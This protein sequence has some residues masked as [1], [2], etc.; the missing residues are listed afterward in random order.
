MTSLIRE[1]PYEQ[2]ISIISDNLRRV[3]RITPQRA[4]SPLFQTESDNEAERPDEEYDVKRK[5]PRPRSPSPSPAPQ[6]EEEEPEEETEQPVE[7]DVY[8]RYKKSQRGKY[9]GQMR[10]EIA[11]AQDQDAPMSDEHHHMWSLL[12]ERNPQRGMQQDKNGAR[13]MFVPPEAMAR[14][15]VELG[16]TS[17]R[18]DC[19]ECQTDKNVNGAAKTH[20]DYL[21]SYWRTHRKTVEPA[22]LAKTI[23][24]LFE[25]TIRTP[26]NQRI[27]RNFHK[28][29]QNTKPRLLQSKL[30]PPWT[31]RSVFDHY[32]SHDIE[33]NNEMMNMIWQWKVLK[34]ML[35]EEHIVRM[36]MLKPEERIL[37]VD[38]N[39]FKL[40]KIA[41]EMYISLRSKDPN[42]W[43]FSS[44][45]S[46]T[47]FN[48]SASFAYADVFQQSERNTMDNL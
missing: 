7:K 39:G 44:T 13:F 31:P 1:I 2:Q 24:K 26:I 17:N 8:D 6:E 9:I 32:Y 28:V 5:R 47:D 37:L 48:R 29:Y 36:D 18:H 27:T 33:A 19:F 40:F 14:I 45:E 25:T 12:V 41:T 42:K 15:Q 3:G 16:P 43:C 4:P 10:E 46:S 11:F 21:R 30:I 20:L 23:S 35:F 34:D 22:E 38:S